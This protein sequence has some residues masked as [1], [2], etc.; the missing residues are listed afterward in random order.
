M[1]WTA[2]LAMLLQINVVLIANFNLQ[3]LDKFFVE[4]LYQRNGDYWTD[5]R[6]DVFKVLNS[7]VNII[8]SAS[9]NN[10][11]YVSDN[12]C[13]LVVWPKIKLPDWISWAIYLIP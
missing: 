8:F 5:V 11:R 12:D 2:S 10:F 9:K 7:F 1:S 13:M 6:V 4:Q 3:F